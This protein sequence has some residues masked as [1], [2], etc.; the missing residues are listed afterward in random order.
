MD[1]ESIFKAHTYEIHLIIIGIAKYI[2][3][4]YDPLQNQLR[5]KLS[6]LSLL[7]YK[8]ILL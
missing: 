5:S 8:T 4:L 1:G 2:R 3:Y 7:F 6:F